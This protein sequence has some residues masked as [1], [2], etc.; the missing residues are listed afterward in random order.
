MSG[1]NRQSGQNISLEAHIRQSVNDILTT[2]I[3]TRVKRRAYGS[4]LPELIDQPLTDALVLQIYAASVMAIT[5]FEPRVTVQ[6]ITFSLDK[7]AALL[8]IDV[9]RIDGSS[10]LTDSITVNLRSQ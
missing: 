5:Q 10:Q 9:I 8:S 4:L 7:S 2:P 3:G 1:M 6:K